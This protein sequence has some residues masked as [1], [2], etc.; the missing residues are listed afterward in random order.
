MT[1]N[2]I[3]KK[4][5]K[6]SVNTLGTII[7]FI[8]TLLLILFAKEAREGIIFGIKLSALSIIPSIFPFFILSDLLISVYKGSDGPIGKIFEKLFNIS[9]YALP[10]FI[11]GILC[12]F[13]L[14]VK[15]AV[16]LKEIG[17]IDRDECET[18]SGFVN[19][20][21]LAFVIS[22]VGI[23]MR[24]NIFD[25][26]ILYISV[27]SSSILTGIIFR[28]KRDKIKNTGEI[29][30]Q[31][32][33]LS[34]SIKNAGVSSIVVSSYIIFFSML[35][36]LISAL[37]K[38]DMTTTLISPLFE[39]GNASK[40]I[41]T[42]TAFPENFS[43]TLTSFSLGFSGLSVFMQSISYLPDDI[44]KSKILIMKFIQ[45]V[46]CFAITSLILIII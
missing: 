8:C 30:R 3:I 36:S 20:P 6:I 27:I 32:F 29:K 17:V 18:L 44:S 23:G 28:S 5:K 7:F 14:G 11:V 16:S 1:A 19:N 25:G 34:L 2:H 43:L 31:N 46:L 38:N 21:S 10:A 12:G 24:G 33:N 15:T 22:G 42:L 40:L 35:L 37:I 39:V 13:P 9:S 26:I 4:R 45:G 41:S